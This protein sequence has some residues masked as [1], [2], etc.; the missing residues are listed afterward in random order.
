[1]GGKLSIQGLTKKWQGFALIDINLE[2][3]DSEYFI[4]V[5]PTGSGKTLL[6]ETINGFHKVFI[7]KI[8]HNGKEITELPPDE[9]ELGY[10]PQTPNLSDRMTVR[11][12]IEYILKKRGILEERKKV[13]DGV[14]KMMGI[15]DMQNR[16]A[17]TLSGGE[18][19]K[20]ALARA[21]VLEPKTMLLDEPFSNLDVI[22]KSDLRDEIKMIH[23]YLDLTII[24]VTH[25][26]TEA[27]GLADRIGAIKNGQI[28][29]IGTIEEVYSDP[30]D[31]YIARFLGYGNIHPAHLYDGLKKGTKIKVNENIIKSSQVTRQKE[32]RI[33][34]HNDEII[35][36][37][38]K[39]KNKKNN[40]YKALV[41]NYMNRGAFM[42]IVADMGMELKINIT[43]KRFN[44]LKIQQDQ[45]IWV[46][47]DENSVKI[48]NLN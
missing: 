29:N 42:T 6:L 36:S 2:I 19:H 10:V 9:R 12:N 23:E 20:V 26:Q 32:F 30:Q 18:K 34:I 33:G 4:L 21:L 47:F 7:G 3:K 15:E 35:I 16:L 41:K 27:L 48:L 45:E 22:M 24:H 25:D 37:K 8:L 13:V 40:N 11:G 28:V 17:Y 38:R 39:P 14:I 46:S 1:V 5:G 44:E 31:E 43:K